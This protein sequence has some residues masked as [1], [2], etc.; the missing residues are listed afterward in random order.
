M[1][2]CESVSAT[3]LEGVIRRKRMSSGDRERKMKKTGARAG[4]RALPANQ[5][6][7]AI[8]VRTTIKNNTFI[9]TAVAPRARF[10]LVN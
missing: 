2:S 1:L 3:L 9:T 6:A 4:A 10:L 7:G 5:S 8:L